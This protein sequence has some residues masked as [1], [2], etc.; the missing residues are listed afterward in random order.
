MAVVRYQMGE[1]VTSIISD[2]AKMNSAQI[3]LLC[4][5]KATKFIIHRMLGISV[6]WKRR[7][8]FLIEFQEENRIEELRNLIFRDSNLLFFNGNSTEI[9]KLVY[10]GKIN[11][12]LIIKLNVSES[13]TE[14]FCPD[15][16]VSRSG[17]GSL[18]GRTIKVA[19]QPHF[20]F[21]SRESEKNSGVDI[22]LL[23]ILSEYLNFTYKIRHS[24]DGVWGTFND[25]MIGMI[26][27]EEVDLAMA[28]MTVTSER[29]AAADFSLAYAFDRTVFV[30]RAP[31]QKSKTWAIFL[32][33]A[34]KT[35]MAIAVTIVLMTF[36]LSLVE[37]GIF[38]SV[39]RTKPKL[40]LYNSFF[41]IYRAVI[42]QGCYAAISTRTRIVV[43]CWW[44]YVLVVSTYYTAKLMSYLTNPGLEQPVDTVPKLIE[45]LKAG[46]YTCGTIKSSSDYALFKNH[47]NPVILETMNSD[48]SNFVKHDVEGLKKCLEK[49]Y[50]YIAGELTIKADIRYESKFLFSKDTFRVFGYGIALSKRFWHRQS[51]DHVII[52]LF[53]AGIIDKWIHSLI[54]K[55]RMQTIDEDRQN[56]L[57]LSDLQSVF[58]LFIIGLIIAIIIFIIEICHRKRTKLC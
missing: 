41:W 3:L 13:K 12:T 9:L 26:R 11:K 44:L 42:N 45:L 20:P 56:P 32:P 33:F 23:D 47:S 48:S 54:D 22:K 55:K 28:G 10:N 35:W 50:A 57:C 34:R 36:V 38:P 6:L 18:D 31:G 52:R 15:G 7:N 5:W 46:T 53:E 8:V 4:D 2:L 14:A 49:N 39:W 27:R 30:T 24:L 21:Y 37:N 43:S 40:T 1:N 16:A 19:L 17:I 51:F 25:G 58:I 29:S